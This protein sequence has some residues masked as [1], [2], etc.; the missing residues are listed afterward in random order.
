MKIGAVLAFTDKQ[1]QEHRCTVYFPTTNEEMLKTLNL[2]GVT[3]LDAV[4]KASVVKTYLD[5]EFVGL[6]DFISRETVI[7]ELNYLAVKMSALDD[8]NLDKL[9]AVM[10]SGRHFADKGVM[11]GELADMIN[12]IANLDCFQFHP[13]FDEQGYGEHL[14]CGPDNMVDEIKRVLENT[15]GSMGWEY[16]GL[17]ESLRECADAEQFGR[18]MSYENDGDF[19]SDG[20]I[21]EDG[22]FNAE[23]YGPA[24]IPDEYCLL[25]APYFGVAINIED[26][27]LSNFPFVSAAE[28]TRAL[29]MVQDTDLAALLLEMHAVGGDYMRDAKYNIKML[30]EGGSDFFVL[31]NGGM[32]VISPADT[33][34]LNDTFEHG[35]WLSLADSPDFKAYFLSVEER[36]D[37]QLNGSLYEAEI[38]PI[39]DSIKKLGVNFTH[40]DAEMKDGTSRTINR[41]EWNAMDQID[42]DQLKSWVKHYD[43]VQKAQIS[44]LVGSLR[45]AYGDVRQPMTAGAFIH[46]INEPY[47]EQANN[48]KPGMI[49]VTTDAARELTAQSAVDVY[50][51]S[52][53]GMDKLSPIDAVKTGLWYVAD[54]EFA[55]KVCDLAGLEKWAQKTAKDMVRQ[56]ER[57]EHKKSREEAL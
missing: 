39:Q 31:D 52:Q 11:C 55:V 26:G 6:G 32:L 14:L 25:D 2:A 15:P 33:L 22:H 9:F 27:A 30:A 4:S 45:F 42:R 54:R 56:T 24:A 21:I 48:D 46:R 19:V 5:K 23:Y 17:V 3:D 13:N 20:Y 18:S 10:E 50:R 57:G 34:Y 1:N 29:V 43:P 49:R 41:A 12:I 51:L 35:H 40:L 53:D 36:K 37:G 38:P 8:D 16:A 47:M 7:S 44:A 28:T